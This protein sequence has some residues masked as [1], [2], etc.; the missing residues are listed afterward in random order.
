M[1]GGSFTHRVVARAALL[2]RRTK[3]NTSAE[4]KASPNCGRRCISSSPSHW[5]VVARSRSAKHAPEHYVLFESWLSSHVSARR[6]IPNAGQVSTLPSETDG[7]GESRRLAVSE[8]EEVTRRRTDQVP[9][10]ELWRED[11]G[12]AAIGPRTKTNSGQRR[13]D[14]DHDARNSPA[15]MP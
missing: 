1:F 10:Q 6:G 5:S 15:S 4:T 8:N 2:F 3:P 12:A 9:T 7:R 11:H 14:A 13:E